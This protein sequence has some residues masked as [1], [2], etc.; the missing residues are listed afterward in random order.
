MKKNL[1]Y[2]FALI[3]SVTLF[4]ACSDDDEAPALTLDN[5]V[6]TYGGTINLA[7]GDGE[8]ADLPGSYNLEVTKGEGSTVTIALRNFAIDMGGDATL[9]LGDIV[10]DCT[11][12]VSGNTASIS[13]QANVEL[14]GL[15]PGVELPTTVTGTCNGTNLSLDI[16]VTEVPAFETVAVVFTGTK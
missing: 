11:A 5:V 15:F 1:L 14:A 8:A 13:G 9:P 10:V 4:T 2:L 3:C 12:T 6:G 16:D 7:V